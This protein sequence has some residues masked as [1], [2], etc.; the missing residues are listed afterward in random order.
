MFDQNNDNSLYKIL[1]AHVAEDDDN[2]GF[3]LFANMIGHYFD[4]TYSYIKQIS[5]THNR[6][7]S[8][9]DGFSKDE[10]EILNGLAEEIEEY[11]ETNLIDVAFRVAESLDNDQK[12]ALWSLLGSTTRSALKKYKQS[13][14]E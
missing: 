5:L 14:K 11:M 13:M 8:L 2:Q 6:D 9:L 3:L 10:I 4:L 1:P 7:Q 12:T